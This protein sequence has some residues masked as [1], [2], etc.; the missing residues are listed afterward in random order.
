MA[1]QNVDSASEQELLASTSAILLSEWQPKGDAVMH[2]S[3]KANPSALSISK[4]S[5]LRAR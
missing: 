1:Q 5:G 3:E 4:F 2:G